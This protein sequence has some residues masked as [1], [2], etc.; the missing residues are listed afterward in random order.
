MKGSDTPTKTRDQML[1]A[2]E[3]PFKRHGSRFEELPATGW[4][5]PTYSVDPDPRIAHP[6]RQ[7]TQENRRR[8]P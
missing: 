5:R 3:G 8:L 7:P 1:L 2:A 6:E 4:T